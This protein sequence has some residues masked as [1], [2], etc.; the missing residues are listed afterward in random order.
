MHRCIDVAV[1]RVVLHVENVIHTMRDHPASSG[2]IPGRRD[3]FLIVSSS[4]RLP[5][6]ENEIIDP[7]KGQYR[8]CRFSLNIYGGARAHHS[9]INLYADEYLARNISLSR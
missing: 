6:A 5:E 9:K 4:A 7:L 1:R 8:P 2:K 3:T